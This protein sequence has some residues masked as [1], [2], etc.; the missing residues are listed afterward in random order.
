[1]HN[2]EILK[3]VLTPFIYKNKRHIENVRQVYLIK[4]WNYNGAI[5]ISLLKNKDL[6]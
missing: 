5:L 4:L 1:M 6:N 2:S 3:N